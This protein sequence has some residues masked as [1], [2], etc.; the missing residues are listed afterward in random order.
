MSPKNTSDNVSNCP[1]KR[2]AA[3]GLLL[4][5]RFRWSFGTVGI[6]IAAQRIP[7]MLHISVDIFAIVLE[8]LESG[9]INVNKH[10]ND[11]ENSNSKS[12]LKLGIFRTVPENFNPFKRQEMGKESCAFRPLVVGRTIFSGSGMKFSGKFGSDGMKN[13]YEQWNSGWE[14]D[15]RKTRGSSSFATWNIFFQLVS[16]SR[17]CCI[18]DMMPCCCPS[19]HKFGVWRLD[20]DDYSR[21]LF[22]SRSDWFPPLFVG[23]K[24]MQP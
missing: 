13:S 24:T 10:D 6:R 3:D 19:R 17:K 14:G 21:S 12:G 4:G 5:R 8:V 22:V 7:D 18:K 2:N 11:V 16:Q 15:I 9:S 20:S 23:F 1:S